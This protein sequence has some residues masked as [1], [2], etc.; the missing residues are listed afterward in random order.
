M[1]EQKPTKT[2][3]AINSKF[4]EAVETPNGTPMPFT[5]KHFQMKYVTLNPE[6]FKWP[7]SWYV[8]DVTEQ[9][10]TSYDD[11]KNTHGARRKTKLTIV[12]G[13][14]AQV[15]I[16]A[17]Q[18]VETLAQIECVVWSGNKPIQDYSTPDTNTF[19][20]LIRPIPMLTWVAGVN[21]GSYSAIRFVADDYEVI[22]NDP[23]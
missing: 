11:D 3:K 7:E 6:Q 4:G 9:D 12:D 8:I 14:T 22:S 20:K 17:G 16:S 21:G 19:I 2:P 5:G 10:V 13:D 23:A 15:L 18:P 1:T